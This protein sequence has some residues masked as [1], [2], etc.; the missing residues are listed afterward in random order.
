LQPVTAHHNINWTAPRQQEVFFE[1]K[2]KKNKK[3]KKS[4]FC[5][6]KKIYHHYSS[7]PQKLRQA[8]PLEQKAQFKYSAIF[9][10]LAQWR[11]RDFLKA[12]GVVCDGSSSPWCR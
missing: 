12:E 8:P 4:S 11:P 9:C 2:R 6:P 1:K 5:W 10:K 7:H 3:K